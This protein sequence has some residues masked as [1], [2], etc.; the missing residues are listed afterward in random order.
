[1]IKIKNILI[2]L[3][4]LDFKV[5]DIVKLNPKV[6]NKEYRFKDGEENA[7]IEKVGGN[8]IRLVGQVASYS[9]KELILA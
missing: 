9:I 3:G 1:M 7:C 5:G 2:H 8:Y 4:I 6:F